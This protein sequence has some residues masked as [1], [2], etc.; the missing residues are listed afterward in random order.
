MLLARTMRLLSALRQGEHD[1]AVQRYNK[2]MHW[3]D[4]DSFEAEGPPPS[5]AD[6][7][8]LGHAFVSPLLNRRAAHSIKTLVHMGIN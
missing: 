5:D 2:A 4:P 7:Q 1:A 3:L 6:I 8:R